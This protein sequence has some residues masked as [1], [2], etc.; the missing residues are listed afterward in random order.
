MLYCIEVDRSGL[1]EEDMVLHVNFNAK[2]TKEEVFKLLE[3]EDIG[4]DKDYCAAEWYQ[5]D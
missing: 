4:W 3:D 2:P 5:V 1:P